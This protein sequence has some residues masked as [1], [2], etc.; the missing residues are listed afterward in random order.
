MTEGKKLTYAAA[1]VDYTP[2][3]ALKRVAQLRARETSVA[4]V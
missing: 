1:G 2:L 4:S 3:D